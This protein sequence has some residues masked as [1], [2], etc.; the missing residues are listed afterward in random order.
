[1]SVIELPG[2]LVG[3][4]DFEEN[5]T[6]KTLQTDPQ[7]GTRDSLPAQWGRHCQVE[8]LAFV[9]CHVAKHDKPADGILD[10][11]DVRLVVEIIGDIPVRGLGAGSLQ[12]VHGSQVG[13]ARRADRNRT[14]EALPQ[15]P[16]FIVILM[17]M[18]ALLP[19]LF[20]LAPPF[21]DARPPEK[22][23]DA[24]IQT[25]RSDSPWAQRS[26]ASPQV[27]IYLATAAPIERAEAELR[28]RRKKT[29]SP[30]PEPDPDYTEYLR[31][32]REQNLVLAV[33]Y[34]TLAGLGDARESKRMEEESVMIVGKKTYGIVGHFP[35]AP[36][37]PVLRLIFPRVVQPAD[38][39]VVFRLYLGGLNFPEREAE[40]RVKELSWQG[41]LEM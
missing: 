20:F 10:N 28:L 34:P 36:S 15:A 29:K 4:A 32:H 30:M 22:W 40:F 16:G 23:T 1:M 12:G 5:S 6:L 8:N 17:I 19:L 7:Q 25:V 31:D 3:L 2:C 18:R 11:R 41:K 37:D 39:S 13:R 24:E 14:H 9:G 35:P 21:W 38:K 27:V 33:T 26:G